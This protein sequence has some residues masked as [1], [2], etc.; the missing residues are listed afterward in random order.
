[1][2]DL[3]SSGPKMS[4]RNS[5]S[6]KKSVS[7]GGGGGGPAK[8]KSGS[9]AGSQSG[10][11]ALESKYGIYGKMAVGKGA[12]SVVR[13][14]HKWDRTEEKLY[15]VKVGPLTCGVCGR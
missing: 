1:M 3:L 4:R 12:T 9:R 14:A 8:S 10:E 7:S 2:R 13:L 15:A 11:S 6:S 5:A